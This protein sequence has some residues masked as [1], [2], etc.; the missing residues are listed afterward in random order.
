MVENDVALTSTLAVLEA[1]VPGRPPLEQRVLDAMTPRTREAYMEM[2]KEFEER[3][4]ESA[5][6]AVFQ[7]EL[8]FE[9][10]FVEAGGLMG[11]GADPT[12]NGG[13][14]PGFG[15]QRNYELL[16]EAGFTPVKAIQIMTGNGARIVDA[17]DEYGSVEAGK[18]ADLVL[19][20]GNPLEDDGEIR[21]VTTVFKHGV[22]YDSKKLIEAVQGVVGIR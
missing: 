11:A 4:R 8:E 5:M 21:N 15:D 22:G 1:L 18:S 7:K 9:K 19:I 2:R 10:A 3:E 12:G 14:L 6:G 20:D 16:L 17:F 13:S